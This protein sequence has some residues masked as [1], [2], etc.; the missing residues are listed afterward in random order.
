MG[1]VIRRLS[2]D[3]HGKIIIF[4]KLHYKPFH[5]VT[6]GSGNYRIACAVG[7]PIKY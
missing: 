4:F 1:R 6:I 3:S 7:E 2:G 5:S